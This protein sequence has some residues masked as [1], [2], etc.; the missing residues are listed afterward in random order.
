M[1]L[2]NYNFPC[3]IEHISTKQEGNFVLL[4]FSFRGKITLASIYGPNEDRPQFYK[5]LKQKY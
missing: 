4:K 5:N 1:L 3:D 2:I